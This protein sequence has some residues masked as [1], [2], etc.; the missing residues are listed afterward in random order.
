MGVKARP[1]VFIHQNCSHA[2]SKI[3]LVA[4]DLPYL[5]LILQ[6][7]PQIFRLLIRAE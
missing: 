1:I 2:L 3:L 4:Q 5:K 6:A 7:L